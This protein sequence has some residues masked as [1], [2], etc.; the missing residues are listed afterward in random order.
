MLG[1][2]GHLVWLGSWGGDQGGEWAGG[3]AA[4]GGWEQREKAWD[5]RVSS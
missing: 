4:K 3:A 5:T 1:R 2:R